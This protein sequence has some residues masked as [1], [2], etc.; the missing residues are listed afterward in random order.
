MNETTIR[1]KFQVTE[2]TAFGNQHG[3]GKRVNL[4][5]RYDDTIAEDRRFAQATPQGHLE[6]HVNNPA[7]EALLQPDTVFY[8]D[9]TP[10][11]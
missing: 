4:E 5:A 3:S 2:V 7:V 1:A 6:M 10:V 8:V 9:F 11:E